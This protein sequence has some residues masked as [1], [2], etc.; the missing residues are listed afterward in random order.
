MLAAD[1]LLKSF[2]VHS[3]CGRGHDAQNVAGN[4]S[5]G[6]WT[7]PIRRPMDQE[8][9]VLIGCQNLNQFILRDADFIFLEGGKVGDYSQRV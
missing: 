6:G 5:F 1:N 9:V 7:F 4:P 8:V 2:E 3:G